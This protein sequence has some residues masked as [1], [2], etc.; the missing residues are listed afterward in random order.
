[1]ATNAMASFFDG[2]WKVASRTMADDR[3]EF[4]TTKI[5]SIAR[6][7]LLVAFNRVWVPIFTAIFL[8]VLTWTGSTLLTTKETVALHRQTMSNIEIHLAQIDAQFAELN[9]YMSDARR[10]RDA[11]FSQAQRQTDAQIA[12]IQTQNE[13]LAAKM[14]MTAQSGTQTIDRLSAQMSDLQARFSNF[15]R[16]VETYLCQQRSPL[17]RS[18]P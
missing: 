9:K 18:E 16:D 5:E 13:L 17:C 2:A 11:Q 4:P 1:M 10:Q 14:D 8:A 6:N 3:G 15:H 7:T 12:A